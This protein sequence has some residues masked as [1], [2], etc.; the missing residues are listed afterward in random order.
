MVTANRTAAEWDRKMRELKRKKMLQK[1]QARERGEET[2]SDDNDDDDN[3]VVANVDR[4]VLEGEDPLTGTH[5]F[6]QGPFPF[7]VGGSESARTVEPGLP[8]GPVGAGGGSVDGRGQIRGRP[9]GV[10]GRG[11]S[12]AMPCE[13]MEGDGSIAVPH[14]S[15]E[16]SSPVAA[17]KGPN[18]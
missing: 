8:L 13:L 6:V 4:H 12:D 18:G 15:M 3:E 11:G 7:H 5:L 17:L 2:G 16:G 9:R 10:D 1:Q 14:E